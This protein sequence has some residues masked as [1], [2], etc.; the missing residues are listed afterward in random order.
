VAGRRDHGGFTGYDASGWEAK[1]WIVH[2]MYETGDL[3]DDITHDDV[4][5]IKREAGLIN[6][7]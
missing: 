2:A 7:C 4:H 1:V 3:P 6:R 5:R